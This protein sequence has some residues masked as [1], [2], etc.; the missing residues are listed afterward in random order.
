MSRSST[1]IKTTNNSISRVGRR[2]NER[3]SRV[4][5]CAPQKPVTETVLLYKLVFLSRKAAL[6]S[7]FLCLCFLSQPFQNVY[8]N[9]PET[10]DIPVSVAPLLPPEVSKNTAQD[11]QVTNIETTNVVQPNSTPESVIEVIKTLPPVSTTTSSS[12]KE[13]V[14]NKS[15]TSVPVASSTKETVVTTKLT[16]SSTPVTSAVNVSSSTATTTVSSSSGGQVNTNND[17]TTNNL[18][19][20]IQDFTDNDPIVNDNKFVSIVES[21]SAFEFSKNECTRIQDGSFYCQKSDGLSVMEDSLIASPDADGDLE[22]Y[23]VRG[24]VR[25]QITHNI[26]DD[27]SPYY[28][29]FSKNIV[30]HRFIDDRYQVISYD[31][32]TGEEVQLTNTSVNNMQPTRHGDYTVWQRWV[33]NNWEVILYDGSK[34]RQITNSPRH[35]IAPHVRGPLVIWNSRSNDGT[36]SLMT[37]DI[38][39]RTYTTIADGEGV[40][41]SNPRMVVMYEAT[42][43]NG[44]IIMKGFDLVSGEII[45]LH[46]LPRQVPSELPNTDSTGETRAL[47]QSK[48]SPKQAEVVN[49]I[50]SSG[51]STPPLVPDPLLEDGTLDL[52]STSTPIVSIDLDITTETIATTSIPDLVLPL[53]TDI[54]VLS[55]DSATSSQ[56]TS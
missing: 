29:E 8:A 38:N 37:Y 6:L 14:V 51:S 39:D 24:G 11:T 17:S 25:T 18:N 9:E 45:P 42:Y 47:I 12:I 53:V 52:R 26:V 30:W 23:L 54:D 16:S 41:V 3:S 20:D 31:T 34:E 5:E 55:D 32:K 1:K 43:E 15:S 48:P 33:D 28:D 22:I 49:N 13:P 19:T 21:D 44:D 7:I 10:S 56:T 35:D 27:A 46:S 4:F 40:S 2:V 36:Q 50:V